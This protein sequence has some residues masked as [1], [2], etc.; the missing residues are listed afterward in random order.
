M[1]TD[2]KQ[3]QYFLTL[4]NDF[5]TTL[6][7]VELDKK[8]FDTFSIEFSKLLLLIGAEFESVSKTL[9]K[10]VEP[11]VTVG[12]ILDIKAGLLKHFSRICENEVRVPKFKLSFFPFKDWDKGSKLKWWDGYTQIK[13][14][15]LT[16]FEHAKLENVLF[17]IGSLLIVLIYLYR[18][19]DNERSLVG[20]NLVE[21]DGTVNLLIALSEK[22]IPDKK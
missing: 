18:F 19:R 5:L 1:Q 9:L 14:N 7:F 10:H 22:D 16:N 8:N 3:W 6:K 21:A 11:D 2:F 4:E 12:D 13:H 17:S 15:R 20:N